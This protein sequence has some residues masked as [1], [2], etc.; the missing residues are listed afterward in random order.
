MLAD[1]VF[2]PA[3]DSIRTPKVL[4]VRTPLFGEELRRITSSTT[5]R[6]ILLK[7]GTFQVR[8]DISEKISF[9]TRQTEFQ[10]GSFDA[11][12]PTA[13]GTSS[14]LRQLNLLRSRQL[15]DMHHAA[16]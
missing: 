4:T 15:Q 12:G 9:S 13:P 16:N 11:W 3:L 8:Q 5:L 10:G 2:N 7:L 6:L 1:C 14:V